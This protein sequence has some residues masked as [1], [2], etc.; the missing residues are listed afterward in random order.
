MKFL[1]NIGILIFTVLVHLIS[2][3]NSKASLWMKG[4][5]NWAGKIKD[6]IKPGDRTVWIHCASLGEFEQGRPVIEAIKK[7]RPDLKIVLTFFSPSGYEI[8]KNYPDADYICY[9]PLD[10]PG[11]AVRFISLVNPEFV[12]FVKYEFWNNYISEL[13]KKKIPLYLISAIF[14]SEQHFFK[15][16]GSFFRDIL[17]KFKVIFVQDQGS[18]NLLS[19]IQMKNIVLA[20]DTRFDRVVQITG[21]AKEIPLLLKFRGDEKMFLAGSSWRQDEEIIAQYINRYADKMKW[22]FA[23]HE[24][25]N[26]NIERLEKLLTVKCVRLSEFNETAADARVLIIDNIGM[27]SSAYR[28]AYLAAIGGGFGKGIHNILEP[29]CWG[30]PVMFGPR[31]KNF[32]EAVELI[33]EKG[34]ITFESFR[35]FSTILDEWLSDKQFYLKSARSAADYTQKNTGA[36][37]IIIKEILQKDIN[38]LYS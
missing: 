12:I 2:P 37:N 3:F 36:T 22:V 30:I 5:K 9:L 4:R 17:K 23:P 19:G 32:R 28:Y 11:N 38:R 34:A 29:A 10:T 18:Y 35:E 33:I 25:D 14:R 27:L 7:E 15:W 21:T 16:Y 13:Y 24:I 1:Y 31:Y 20:G 8:R 6:K 26:T